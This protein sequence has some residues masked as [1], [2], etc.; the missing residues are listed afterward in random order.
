MSESEKCMSERLEKLRSLRD[1]LCKKETDWEE[2]FKVRDWMVDQ[3]K[4]LHNMSVSDAHSKQDLSERL[5]DI[6]C[7][8]EPQEDTKD[9]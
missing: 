6:L 5:A 4:T 9:E 1:Q 2:A 8:L 7:A 3:L